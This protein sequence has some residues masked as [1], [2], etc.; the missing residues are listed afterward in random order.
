[1]S[2]FIDSSIFLRLL[3]NESGADLAQNILE[4]VEA[5]KVIAYTSP[6]V[7]EEISFK[8][9]YAKASEL[10]K[11]INIWRIREEFKLNMNFRV[12]YMKPIEKFHECIGFLSRRGLRIETVTYRDWV[13]SIEISKKYG[14][15]PANSVHIA[16][17][18][19]VDT[20]ATFNTD[21][22]KIKNIN[23]IPLILE[24]L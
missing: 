10:L 2:I 17:R 13:K 23:V 9:I 3:L 6:M 14:M 22:K 20:I 21:F 16:M 7:L 11:T 19:G 5:N 18:I 15:F 4:N 24:I 1:M 12:E 8:L